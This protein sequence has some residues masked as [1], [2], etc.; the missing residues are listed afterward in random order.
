MRDALRR[1]LLRG[2]SADGDLVIASARQRSR[3][4]ELAAACD[5]AAEA[6]PIAGVAVA[7]ECGL[8]GLEALDALTGA[9]TREDVLDA[10][11]ARFCIGK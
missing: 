6:L 2:E 7:S 8:A 3:L 10:L 5:Q 4:L 1:V 11:F 9:D